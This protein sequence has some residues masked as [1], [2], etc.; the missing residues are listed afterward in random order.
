M[1]ASLGG[2]AAE[3]ERLLRRLSMLAVPTVMWAS[4]VYLG[5]KTRGHLALHMEDRGRVCLGTLLVT[6]A[7]PSSHWEQAHGPLGR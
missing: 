6:S 5:K 4:P 7:L 3:E 2:E 1:G